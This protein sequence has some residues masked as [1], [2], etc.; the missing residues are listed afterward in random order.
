MGKRSFDWE[1]AVAMLEDGYT[2]DGVRRELG[3]TRAALWQA[4]AKLGSQVRFKRGRKPVD[5]EQVDWLTRQGW[6]AAK[7][8]D[9]L[10]VSSRTVC[11]S[12]ARLRSFDA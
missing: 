5:D 10:K 11:R 6:S 4:R 9:K 3:C 2:L 7:I 1:Q 8:A 12:R